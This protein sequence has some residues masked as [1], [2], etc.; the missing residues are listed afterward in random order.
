MLKTDTN[1][2]LSYAPTKVAPELKK[3]DYRRIYLLSFIILNTLVFGVSAILFNQ[4]QQIYFQGLC[5]GVVFLNSLCLVLLNQKILYGLVLNFF[6][7]NNLLG[8]VILAAFS[9]GVHSPYAYWLVTAPCMA[10]VLRRTRMIYFWIFTFAFTLLALFYFQEFFNPFI[11]DHL[12]H[13]QEWFNYL[14]LGGLALY[15]TIFLLLEEGHSR[16]LEKQSEVMLDDQ[17]YLKKQI[18]ILDNRNFRLVRLYQNLQTAQKV[19]EQKT[20]IIT[21]AAK[22]LDTK[23]RQIRDMRDKFMNQSRTLED[24]N[25]N[26][27]NSIRYAQRI[28]EA[29]TPEKDWVIQH[30]R[31]A[32]IFFRPKDIVSG[33]FYW[34][35]EKKRMGETLKILIAA[36]CTG[37]GVPGAFMTVMGNSLINEIVNEMGIVQPDELLLELDRKVIET[38]S[39]KNGKPEIHDGMD[40]VVMTI[41]EE[42]KIVKY[43]AAH[44]PLYYVRKQTLNQV[45]G[46][47]FAVGSSQYKTEKGF[48]LH[49]IQA[50]PG[51]MFYIFTDGFQDQ[52]GKKQ[53]RKYM[54]RRFRNF[55]LSINRLPLSKQYEKIGAEFA[56]WKGDLPQTDDVLIIGF[57]M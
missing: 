3:K 26:I 33:D 2:D 13:V 5:L 51:D 52:F 40:M 55:L 35:T 56:H 24:I 41:H 17:Q 46:S 42:D 48:K 57:R 31:D 30:F 6:I 53:K 29:I 16:H 54:T 45:K 43:A 14:S 28:Q 36:D 1:T 44:N 9:G 47:K 18:Q 22:L 12:I 23:N 11:Q 7:L 50:E 34:F 25:Q 19:N 10:F 4:S 38:L 27:T 8:F 39:S 32:F 49:T 21:E 15:L 37:H 20:E